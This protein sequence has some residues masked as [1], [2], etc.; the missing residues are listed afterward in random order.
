[1]LNQIKTILACAL[2][3]SLTAVAVRAYFIVSR[4]DAFLTPG[5]LRDLHND[6]TTSAMAAQSTANAYSEIASSTVSLLD[7]SVKPA[8]DRLTVSTDRSLQT[9]NRQIG[10]LTPLLT[11]LSDTTAISNRHLEQFGSDLHANQ[12]ELKATLAF[13]REQVLSE[14]AGIATEAHATSKRIRVLVDDMVDEFDPQIREDLAAVGRILGNLEAVTKNS[15][16]IT[17]HLDLMSADIQKW[18]NK[19]LFPPPQKG[20]GGFMKRYVL[21]PLRTAGGTV[22]LY[23]RIVNGL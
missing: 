9:L 16:G 14:I 22:Y 12:L 19:Q 10:L 20:F 8:V 21:T 5:V 4:V 17:A 15:A 2:L 23:L 6:V 3:V 1:M 13:T 18:T 11:G 7:G